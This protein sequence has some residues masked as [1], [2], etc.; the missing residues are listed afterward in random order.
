[1]ARRKNPEP[2]ITQT[3]ILAM[4]GRSIQAEIIKQRREIAELEA[5]ACTDE[6]RERVA[7]LKE[8]TEERLTYHTNRLEAIETMY[9]IQ[10]GTD[11]GLLDELT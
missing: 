4:A 2:I 7:L 11:L 5:R 1:M 8:M 3:E 9:R 10:T 6:L